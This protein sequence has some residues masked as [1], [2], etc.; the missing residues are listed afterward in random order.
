LPDGI[1]TMALP[2]RSPEIEPVGVNWPV[3]GS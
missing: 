2:E 1:V 3:A